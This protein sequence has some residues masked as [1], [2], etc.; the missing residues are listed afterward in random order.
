MGT[1]L[2]GEL[3]EHAQAPGVRALR[4]RRALVGD[5][6]GRERAQHVVLAVDAD[7]EVVQ[8]PRV[9][10]QLVERVAVQGR[11]GRPG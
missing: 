1:V 3:L 7:E 9:F 5:P 8:L 6:E 4:V 10:G 11:E 2:A